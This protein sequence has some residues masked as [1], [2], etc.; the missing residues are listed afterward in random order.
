M[1]VIEIVSRSG[2]KRDPGISGVAHYHRVTLSTCAG[3]LQHIQHRR[4]L[5]ITGRKN[6]QHAC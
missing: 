5:W 2:A 6:V 1:Y 3:R 4:R